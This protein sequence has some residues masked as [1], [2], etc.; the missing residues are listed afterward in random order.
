MTDLNA[1][2]QANAKRWASALIT[3]NRRAEVVAVA[4]RLAAPAAKSRYQEIAQAVWKRADL[5]FVVAVIHERE[6]SQHWDRQLGQG[7]PLNRPSVNKPRGRGPFQNHDGHDAF[8]WGA[9]DALMNCPPFAGLWT[10]WSVGGVLTLWILYNGTG[11][12]DFHHE[13]SPYDWGATNQEQRGKYV[14]DGKFDP[15][16][17]DMQ[18]GCAAMLM[19]MMAIDPTITFTGATITPNIPPTLPK[20]TVVPS[21]TNPAKGSI[22]AFIASILSA[23]FKRK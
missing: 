20:P 11:Y 14:S 22:G 23:I 4:K 13:A 15:G 7:D 21:V 16:A 19:A 10:D 12:E 6:A 8:Y 1:L 9:V 2:K 5:W 17:W 3:P 18:V